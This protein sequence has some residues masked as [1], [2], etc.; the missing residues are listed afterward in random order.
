MH[1]PA[2]DPA[3]PGDDAGARHRELAA[4]QVVGS[5]GRHLQ[6]RAARVEQPIDPVPDQQLAASDVLGP[7]GFA[8]A[9]S[10]RRQPVPQLI[11]QGG[12]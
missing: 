1:K 10:D 9:P 7:G 8:A 12:Q 11:D 5:Q 3:D 4:V 2:V 6:E